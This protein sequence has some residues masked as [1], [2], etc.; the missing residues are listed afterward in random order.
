MVKANFGISM[1]M[2]LKDNGS[3]IK[4]MGMV[5]I[6]IQMVLHTLG[7]GKTICNTE[8]AKNF[9][10]MVASTLVN[11]KWVKNMVKESTGGLM[12]LRMTEYG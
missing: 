10:S 2:Y 12:A 3:T 4:Q 8:K 1:E 11:T 7:T 5:C 6:L 9:G